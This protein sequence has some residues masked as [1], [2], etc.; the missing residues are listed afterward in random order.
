MDKETKNIF[1]M[2]N[3][4]ARRI[5]I[6]IADQ[7]P[8]DVCADWINAIGVGIKAI[9]AQPFINKPCVSEGVCREDKI[10][11]LNKIKAE[12]E[13]LPIT[14]TA[15]R[16]VTEILDKYKAESEDAE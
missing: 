6:D 9:D 10:Q 13:K 7:M 8:S 2:T 1:E 5:L 3:K 12:V 4:E 16:L 11:V 15:V 14:N